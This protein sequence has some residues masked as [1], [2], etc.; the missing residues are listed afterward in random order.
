MKT[1]YAF[2]KAYWK[3][4]TEAKR[5]LLTSS[6]IRLYFCETRNFSTMILWPCHTAWAPIRASRHS[7]HRGEILCERT[8]AAVFYIYLY[9]DNK[10]PLDGGIYMYNRILHPTTLYL[11]RLTT[12]SAWLGWKQTVTC[13]VVEKP[14]IE[15]KHKL[16][17]GRQIF[18]Y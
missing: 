1:F 10:S 15:S 18:I 8:T 6:F 4:S 13:F 3:D 2:M 11:H 7:F 14:V 12:R 16:Q 5:G 9:S 17:L